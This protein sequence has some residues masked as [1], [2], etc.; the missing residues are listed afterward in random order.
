M[1]AKRELLQDAQ[2][3]CSAIRSSCAD[4]SGFIGKHQDH[5]LPSGQPAGKLPRFNSS[6]RQHRHLLKI[7][8]GGEGGDCSILLTIGRIIFVFTNG[9]QHSLRSVRS[10]SD[11][12]LFR[13]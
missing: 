1:A 10:C 5:G 8:L 6:M 11:G 9:I 3:K 13:R 2:L 4:E 7:T 12:V